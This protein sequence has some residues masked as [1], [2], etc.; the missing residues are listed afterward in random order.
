M[1]DTTPSTRHEEGSDKAIIGRRLSEKNLDNGRHASVKDGTKDCYDHEDTRHLTEIIG[2][3]TV[4]G[5]DG[6]VILD[7]DVNDLHELPD[8]LRSLP[9]TLIVETVHG[10]YHLYYE[11]ESG[12]GISNT[13]TDWGSVR[14]EG[15][16]AVGPG[17]TVDHA[18]YCDDGK[19]SCPQAGI[20]MY[21]IKVD[22][23]IATLTGQHF[24]RLSKVCASEGSDEGGTYE[25]YGGR[26]ITL[27]DEA[28][29][30][31]A[32][33]YICA[34]FSRHST[35]LART[36]LMDLLRGGTGSYE[37][38][39]DRDP[40]SIDQSAADFYALD[41]LYGAF[42]FRGEDEGDA[43]RL[44][45]AVFKRYCRA[46]PYDKTGN[47]RKWLRK[48]DGYLIEQMDAVECEFDFGNWHRWRRREYEN[49]FNAEEHRPWANPSKDGKPSPT[50][51]DTVQAALRMLVMPVDPEFIMHQ[52]GLDSS[53][54]PDPSVGKCV[55]PSGSSSPTESERY[56]TAREVGR[57]A[58]EINPER[59]ASYFEEVLK[60]LCRETNSIA[61]AY[62]PSRP[63][64]ERHLYYPA[65]LSDPSDARWIRVGGVEFNPR[66]DGQPRTTDQ[67]NRR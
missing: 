27:P 2:N 11:V 49:G 61:H 25:E 54:T 21:N 46:N 58:S 1:R 32:E 24:E 28:V 57:V 33:R 18:N 51:E 39:R 47:T 52:Y 59:K 43:R 20:D 62:C 60:K 5:G 55:P 31:P 66:T 7:I 10:G 44:A 41:M 65:G 35:Q 29:A 40:S 8:W 53:H 9:P 13:K 45:I 17:S 37:L 30:E 4:H 48:G 15:W 38:R 12:D 42:L 6:L 56:T 22:R 50:T 19:E 26:K 16:Y 23:P 3:Y 34:D 14:Y 64:G 67:Q 63:N 36:D